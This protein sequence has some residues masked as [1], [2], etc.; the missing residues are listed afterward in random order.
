MSNPAALIAGLGND[1]ARLDELEK[2]L[3]QATDALDNAEEAWLFHL[4]QIG[5]DLKDEAVKAG[6]RPPAEH[7]IVSEA[8]RSNRVAYSNWRRA[9]RAVKLIEKQIGARKAAMNGRQSQLSALR[10]ESR[11]SVGPQPQWSGRAA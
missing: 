7:M 8:R 4:D 1:A 11:A 5:E 10:E 9:E 6:Q 3:E 2:L